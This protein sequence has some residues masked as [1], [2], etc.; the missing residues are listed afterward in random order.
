M[1]RKKG[2]LTYYEYYDKQIKEDKIQSKEAIIELRKI[3][4]YTFS[5]RSEL[6]FVDANFCKEEYISFLKSRFIK[7][8]SKF[9]DLYK[10]K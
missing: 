8:T 3:E 5:D 1:N 10:I 6:N 4:E 9:F 7:V 2:D